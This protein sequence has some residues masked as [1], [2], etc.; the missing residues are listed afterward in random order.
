MASLELPTFAVAAEHGDLAGGDHVG[1]VP[2]ARRGAIEGESCD[3]D[4]G[5]SDVL[6]FVGEAVRLA[7]VKVGVLLFRLPF[8]RL[9]LAQAGG[10]IDKV[11][12]ALR[13][14]QIEEVPRRAIVISHERL[15]GHAA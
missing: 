11:R 14:A 3:V 1:D 10:A 7:W 6:A 8:L 15:G 9:A 5:Q 2:C 12:V 13:R 4:L